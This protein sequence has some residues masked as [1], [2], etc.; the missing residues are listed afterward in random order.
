[1]SSM[2]R[3]GNCRCGLG[4]CSRSVFLVIIG[5]LAAR[6]EAAA[7]C[8]LPTGRQEAKA[9]LS[10][11]EGFDKELVKAVLLFKPPKF[12]ATMPASRHHAK[13]DRHARFL[14]RFGEQFAF[15]Q[16]NDRVLVA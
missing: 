6:L 11:F 8:P 9:G 14:D 1:M 5:K 15:G 10:R 13:C 16:R 3:A 2:A 4:T 7:R 12:R